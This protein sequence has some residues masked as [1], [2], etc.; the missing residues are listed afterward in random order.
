MAFDYSKLSGRITEICGTRQVFSQRMG[1]SEHSIS[2]KL[3]SKYFWKQQE[4]K[5]ACEVL[6]ISVNEI[7]DYFFTEAVQKD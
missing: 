2:K 6:D 1:I 7:P 4:I 3:N 5:R